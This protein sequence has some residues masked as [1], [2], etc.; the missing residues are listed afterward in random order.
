MPQQA[1]VHTDWVCKD[2]EEVVVV[3]A[4]REPSHH[5]AAAG[6]AVQLH[7]QRHRVFAAIRPERGVR[8]VT[9]RVGDAICR[10][11][12]RCAACDVRCKQD[13]GTGQGRAADVLRDIV[14]IADQDRALAAEQLEN[15]ELVAAG[16]AVRSY[17]MSAKTDENWNEADCVT[18]LTAG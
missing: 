4:R 1:V 16:E 2:D 5:P 15:R 12:A 18:G 11:R 9:L 10:R 6:R 7:L 13:L 17:D 3:R 14:V 8:D